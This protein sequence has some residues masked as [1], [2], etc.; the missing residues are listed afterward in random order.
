M[1]FSPFGG[2]HPHP[3]V[4][5]RPL[6]HCPSALINPIMHTKLVPYSGKYLWGPNFVLFVLSLSE[7]KFNT[8][9][10]HYDG[11]VLLCKMDRMK[12]KHTNQLEIAQNKIWTPQKFPAIRYLNNLMLLT[13]LK[14]PLVFEKCALSRQHTLKCALSDLNYGHMIDFEAYLIH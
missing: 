5:T 7:Q 14:Q 3:P 2:A 10:V 6:L 12:I 1:L 4:T 9:N 11:R 8:R 13:Y